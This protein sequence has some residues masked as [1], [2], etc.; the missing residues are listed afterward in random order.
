MLDTRGDVV[1][2]RRCP[3]CPFWKR[4][5]G[6]Y[7]MRR[8]KDKNS[9]WIVGYYDAEDW[10][11]PWEFT[12]D[13]QTYTEERVERE[14]IVGGRIVPPGEKEKRDWDHLNWDVLRE[15]LSAEK[16]QALRSSCMF[17]RVYGENSANSPD[18]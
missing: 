1:T 18:P 13:E 4:E 16:I 6:H 11:R 17:R 12:G 8:K 10:N 9:E 7:W 5:S 3:Y 15:K 2:L 14:F